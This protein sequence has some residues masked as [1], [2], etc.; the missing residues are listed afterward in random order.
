MRRPFTIS[1]GG[2]FALLW[3]PKFEPEF[4]VACYSTSYEVRY[5]YDCCL[6]RQRFVR[7]VQTSLGIC[8]TMTGTQHRGNN[9]TLTS[10][11]SPNIWM[12][13]Y[14]GS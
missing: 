13:R 1:F 4:A 2:V 9:Q 10:C 14:Q 8:L 12:W 11:G 6:G 7:S 3:P 5:A